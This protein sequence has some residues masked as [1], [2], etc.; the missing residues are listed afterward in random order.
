VWRAVL[1][2][3]G[4]RD[5]WTLVEADPAAGEILA[6][7]RTP[8]WKFVDDVWIR[9]SLDE[10]GM[11]RVDLASTSR[12]GRNDFGTNARRIVRFLQ[13]L[14]LLLRNRQPRDQ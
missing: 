11:T 5:R 14:D 12:V 7:A 10:N 1:H 6:E 9:V 3:I 4:R 8:V 2:E 13:R